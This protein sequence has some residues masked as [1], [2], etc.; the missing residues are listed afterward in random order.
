MKLTDRSMDAIFVRQGEDKVL[1]RE[2]IVKR[3]VHTPYGTS[4][5]GR[6]ITIV[7]I[8]KARHVRPGNKGNQQRLDTVSLPVDSSP[9]CVVAAF[10]CPFCTHAVAEYIV[11][12]D[13][14]LVLFSLHVCDQS[15]IKPAASVVVV[16]VVVGPSYFD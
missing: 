9:R 12:P 1:G 2:W 4:S 6:T 5:I 15:S 11:L 10:P 16:V 13:S 14:I 7:E 8:S 3:Q